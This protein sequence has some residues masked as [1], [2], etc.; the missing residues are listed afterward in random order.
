MWVLLAAA[1][2]VA[3]LGAAAAAGGACG[4]AEWSCRG[5]G[6]VPGDAYCDGAAQC[7]DGSDEP[8]RCTPCNRTYYGRVGRA[9]RL[10]LP[11]APPL[12]FLCHLT[13]T[14][15]G[16]AHGELV[17]LR[18]EQF[19]VGRWL[20]AARE[21][22]PDG[23][24]QLAELGRPFTGGAWCGAAAGAALYYSE[25]ST[26][27]LSVRLWARVPLRLALQYRT[28]AAREAVVRYGAAGAPLERGAVSPGT[29]CTRSLEDCHRLRCRLQSPNWPGLY[30]RNVSCYWSVRQRAAPTCK[31]AMIS[32]RQDHAHLVQIKR[33]I[34]MA[35]S[36]R[37]LPLPI[38]SY[39]TR[40][41][42]KL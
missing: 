2:A 18:L 1:A 26:V 8:P 39:C 11:E 12:P 25:T 38:S 16:G 23:L 20:G 22:C 15:G 5:G 37:C 33:S 24:A 29:Y 7:S 31:H 32:V 30:P 17:Q 4:V 3:W 36:L 41:A 10:A 42:F 13:F 28:L 19:A 40:S 27:T 34:S 35:R 9:Y 21:P 6:C 14:A